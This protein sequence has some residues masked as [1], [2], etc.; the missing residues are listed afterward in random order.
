M[1][2]LLAILLLVFLPYP[3]N[4]AGAL[5]SSLVGAVEVLF[6]ER[7]MR[8]GPVRTGY[9]ALVG[10]TGEA[11]APLTPIGQVRVKG[12]LWEAHSPTPIERGGRVEVV[13]IDDLR[14]EVRPTGESSGRARAAGSAGMLLLV[15]LALAGC[16]GDD[17]SASENYANGVC[18]SLGTW[19][20]EVQETVQS[21]TDAGLATT[22]EDLQAS[23]DETKDATETLVNDLEQLGPPETEDGERVKSELDALG[24][25][26][27]RQIDAIE[28]ALDAGGGV[29]AV[30][31]E[32]STAIS[33]AANAVKTTYE[34]L[35]GL[36][37]AG[38]LREAFED[39]DDCNALEDQL[40]EIGSG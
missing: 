21:L 37:P 30:A 19:V 2:L 35:Q 9:E 13:A 31:A 40:D 10:A 16:G 33:A 23:W 24:T 8:S 11:V 15:V 6:W 36:D 27:T 25:E 22:R 26:L 34:D 20:T 3:W 18:M 4:L 39:S 14:L 5:A 29:T 17:S 1:F 28:Q 38:E 32:V 12:E 7:R